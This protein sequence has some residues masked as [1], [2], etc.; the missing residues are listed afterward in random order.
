M[1]MSRGAR[2]RSPLFLYDSFDVKLALSRYNVAGATCKSFS[3]LLFL[4]ANF[5]RCYFL[6]LC[7]TL[8]F[9]PSQS[10]SYSSQE[11][12]KVVVSRTEDVGDV[13]TASRRFVRDLMTI[14]SRFFFLLTA[15]V[16]L[17]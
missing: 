13:L 4:L 14:S 5:R 7:H 15:P 8:F 3:G 1:T 11:T 2:Q 17:S 12:F 16:Q 10:A 6:P 9:Q